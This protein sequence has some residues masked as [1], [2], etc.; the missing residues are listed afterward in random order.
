MSE[1]KHLKLDRPLVFVDLETT[2]VNTSTDR[3]VEM[4]VLKIHPDGSKEEKSERVNPGIPI[5]PDATKVH[6]ITNED[7]ADKPGFSQYARSIHSFFYGCDIGGFNA[8]RFDIPLLTAEFKRVGLEF[9]LEGRKVV[10]PMVIFYQHEPRDLAAAYE[11]YCGKSLDNAHSSAAD[12]QA[13]AEIF[14]AQVRFY[15][16]LPE[17]MAELHEVCHPREPDWIDDEG[18]L[19]QSEQ[20]PLIAFGRY[21]GRSLKELVSEDPGYLQWILSQDFSRQVK[22]VVDSALQDRS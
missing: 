16:E 3:I 8:I 4:T 22:D 17:E 21:N 7:V 12:V 9:D 13:A 5:S 6:G 10:D 15:P 20:G 2:G 19:I 1:T 14:E 18:K 11:K